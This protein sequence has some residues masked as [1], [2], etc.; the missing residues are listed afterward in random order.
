MSYHAW[1]HSICVIG[2]GISQLVGARPP[3]LEAHGLILGISTS[4]LWSPRLFRL[5]SV[6]CSLYTYIITLYMS[7]NKV[8][9]GYLQF[10]SNRRDRHHRHL[11]ILSVNYLLIWCQWALQT[12]NI[13]RSLQYPS[14]INLSSKRIALSLVL[15]HS[16]WFQQR[17]LNPCLFSIL[18]KIIADHGDLRRSGIL[19]DA[20]VLL[21]GHIRYNLSFLFI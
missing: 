18:R 19:G 14:V 7:P 6:V 8:W 1:H 12:S 9:L 4:S 15:I 16:L 13:Y 17:F 2:A 21:L 3:E 11:K 5:N 20:F 10:S